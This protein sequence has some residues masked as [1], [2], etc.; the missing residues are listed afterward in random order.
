MILDYEH[1]HKPL[2]RTLL[3]RIRIAIVEHG[4]SCI[5]PM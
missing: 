3:R 2:R 4:R 1:P 5:T